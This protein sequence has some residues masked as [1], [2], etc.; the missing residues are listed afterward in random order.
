MHRCH[1]QMSRADVIHR[2]HVQMSHADVIH[3]CHAQMS[4]MD[5]THER[6]LMSEADGAYRG[7][8]IARRT[9]H[10]TV[11]TFYYSITYA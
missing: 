7:H 11:V 5:V 9:W 8:V 1:V 10:V 2:C 4:R 6:M 3:R